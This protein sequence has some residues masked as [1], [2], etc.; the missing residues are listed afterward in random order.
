MA[1]MIPTKL[2][3][4]TAISASRRTW[5]KAERRGSFPD[6]GDR[7]APEAGLAADPCGDQDAAPPVGG[8]VGEDSEQARDAV[9][10]LGRGR[11]GLIENLRGG[12]LERRGVGEGGDRTTTLLDEGGSGVHVLL[13]DAQRDG[14]LGSSFG[15]DIYRCPG[16]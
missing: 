4:V 15:A 2:R 12:G 13:A 14:D 5:T 7:P 3:M 6:R 9:P 8:A 1:A 11:S 16:Q 10:A